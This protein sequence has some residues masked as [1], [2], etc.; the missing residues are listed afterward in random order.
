MRLRHG[1]FGFLAVCNASNHAV[2]EIPQRALDESWKRWVWASPMGT[3][4]TGIIIA[5]KPA[6]ITAFDT[7]RDSQRAVKSEP[8]PQGDS[9][10]KGR[11]MPA[12]E[13]STDGVPPSQTAATGVPEVWCPP[14]WRECHLRRVAPRTG[15]PMT[16]AGSRAAKG[17]RQRTRML[18]DGR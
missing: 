10:R 8:R 18:S 12:E 14:E 15:V 4:L 3:H 9:M 13:G 6:S 2:A 5:R 16:S 7:S 11:A 1:R 17:A